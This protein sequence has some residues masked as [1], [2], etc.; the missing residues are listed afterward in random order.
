[1]IT[2]VKCYNR[3]KSLRCKYVLMY[4]FPTVSELRFYMDVVILFDILRDDEKR[5]KG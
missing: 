3:N 1:M 5:R 2:I 4:V